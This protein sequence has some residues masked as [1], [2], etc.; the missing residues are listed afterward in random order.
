MLLGAALYAARRELYR[1]AAQGRLTEGE[2]QF[3]VQLLLGLTLIGFTSS[4]AH[5]GVGQGPQQDERRHTAKWGRGF[6]G[7]RQGRHRLQNRRRHSRKSLTV[8]VCRPSVSCRRHAKRLNLILV[9]KV[10][11][12][13]GPEQQRGPGQQRANTQPCF[14][15]A[16]N[17]LQRGEECIA[18]N[19]FLVLCFCRALN[20]APHG[21]RC[22]P[23]NAMHPPEGPWT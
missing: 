5:S 23:N 20:E 1:E 11:Q 7:L 17:P 3:R 4:P 12:E 22:I 14:N 2:G 10:W 19:A 18:N 6:L 21:D 13:G 9:S 16:I 8:Y 15:G